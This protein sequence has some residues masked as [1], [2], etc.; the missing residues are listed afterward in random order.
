MKKSKEIPI[1]GIGMINGYRVMAM[2][3][4]LENNCDDCCFGLSAGYHRECP[5]NKCFSRNRE[6]K[7]HVYFVLVKDELNGK[8]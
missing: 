4:Q 2:E 7:K 5:I 8:G 1:G 3:F 6:D